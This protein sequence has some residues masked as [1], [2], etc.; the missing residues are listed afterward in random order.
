L[1]Y[2]TAV[3]GDRFLAFTN[4]RNAPVETEIADTR[5]PA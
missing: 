2:S 5:R 3:P 1:L 4:A